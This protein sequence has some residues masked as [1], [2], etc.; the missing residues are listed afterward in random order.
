MIT[1]EQMNR[2]MRYSASL[3]ILRRLHSAGL[4]TEDE[5]CRGEQILRDDIKPVIPQLICCS[6][7]S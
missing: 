6:V 2:Q 1:T 7:N 3:T 4:I 5:L